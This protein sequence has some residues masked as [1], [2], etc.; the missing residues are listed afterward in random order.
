MQVLKLS[1][2]DPV[3]GNTAI[4]K[5]LIEILVICG[6]VATSNQFTFEWLNSDNVLSIAGKMGKTKRAY[7]KISQTDQVICTNIFL[8]HKTSKII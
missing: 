5:I 2:R 7:K 3:E 8:M 6:H 1:Y 4:I